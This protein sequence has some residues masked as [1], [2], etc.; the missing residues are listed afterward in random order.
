MVCGRLARRIDSVMFR[1][2]TG[3]REFLFTLPKPLFHLFYNLVNIAL[4]RSHKW[5]GRLT[6]I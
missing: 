2:R 3:S 4:E 1:K 5:V 6:L